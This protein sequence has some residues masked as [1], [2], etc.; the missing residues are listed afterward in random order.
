[1]ELLLQTTSSCVPP[2]IQYAAIEAVEGDQSAVKMM[3]SEYKERMQTLVD[4]LN[5]IKGIACLAPGGAIYIF[6]NISGTGMTSA[7]FA[8]FALEKAG[9]AVLPGTNVGGYGEGYRRMC[10]VSSREDIEKGVKRLKEA[11]EAR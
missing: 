9:V 8:D 3:V 10:V 11:I 1:M 4:G 7:E 5:D 2:F 6:P